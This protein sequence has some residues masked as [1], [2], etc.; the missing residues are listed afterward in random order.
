MTG[1]SGGSGPAP[2]EVEPGLEPPGDGQRGRANAVGGDH[3]PHE[4][5]RWRLGPSSPPRS[6]GRRVAPWDRA[7][8]ATHGRL[9]CLSSLGSCGEQW[10]PR[11]K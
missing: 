5:A 3:D 9:D 8:P 1:S 4:G 10:Y 2:S 11:E 7:H 6:A